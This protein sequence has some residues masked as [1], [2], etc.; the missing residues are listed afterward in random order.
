[1]PD[2]AAVELLALLG[3]AQH[4]P[5]AAD[6][7]EITRHL[8]ILAIE[9]VALDDGIQLEVAA[10]ARFLLGNATLPGGLF[11]L[12]LGLATGVVGPRQVRAPGIFPARGTLFLFPAGTAAA[13]ARPGLGGTGLAPA[14]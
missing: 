4:A 1:H 7:L 5:D 14:P 13:L 9:G 10:T 8:R 3:R 11:F 2:V 12:C 6:V